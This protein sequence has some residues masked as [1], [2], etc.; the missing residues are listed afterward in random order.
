MITKVIQIDEKLPSM[1]KIFSQK[2]WGVSKRIKDYWK[3]KIKEHINNIPSFQPPV[4][5]TVESYSVR[6]LDC[7]NLCVKPV[8]D[9]LRHSNV[10]EDDNP[11]WVQS[12]TL[13]SI[14]FSG[15]I[16]KIIIKGKLK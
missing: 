2:H 14:K 12:V 1:N 4:D 13:R 10:I 7:D 9:G 15:E 16:T 8:I 5:I 11:F 3:Q 6:P